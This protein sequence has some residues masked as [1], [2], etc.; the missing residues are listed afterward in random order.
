MTSSS[1]ENYKNI[2]HPDDVDS[3]SL[4][5]VSLWLEWK[6]IPYEHL[7][8][9]EEM[10]ELIRHHLETP[11]SNEEHAKTNDTSHDVSKS[12]VLL[13]EILAKDK[14]MKEEL[15]EVY[16]ELIKFMNTV[17]DD[18]RSVMEQIHGDFDE[19]LATYDRELVN[20]E[21]PIVVA[22]ETSAG[23]SSLL[24]LILGTDVLPHSLLCATSTICRLHNSKSKKFEIITNENEIIPIEVNNENPEKEE[25]L[26]KEK[27]K[28]YVSSTESR[29][30]HKYKQVEIYWPI[31]LLQ[32]RVTIVDTPGVGE[33]DEISKRLFE[34]L[35]N[36]VAFI[37]VINS[38]NSGG[39][40]EDRLLQILNEQ[41]RWQIEGRLTTF[42]YNSTIF[43]CNKWD[44]VEKRHEED[45]V[46]KDTE[47]KLQNALPN[48]PLNQVF[49]MS[50]T[51]AERYKKSRMG[52][53]EKFRSLL[54]GVE[55]LV[56]ASLHAKI[57]R[58]FQFLEMF[59][60]QLQSKIMSRIN[61]A[62]K[63]EEEKNKLY[64]DVV[65]RLNRLN[66]DSDRVKDGL[67][68]T[69][70]AECQQMVN[71]LHEYLQ[72]GDVKERLLSWREDDAPDIEAEDFEVTKFKADGIIV[73]RILKM[74]KDWEEENKLVKVASE[75]LTKMFKEECQI[76]SKDYTDVNVVVEGMV[77][78]DLPLALGIAPSGK[79][80]DALFT[81]SEKVILAVAA[82]LWVPLV[83]AASLLFLPVGVGM[84]IKETIKAG[85]QRRDYR[86]NKVKYMKEWTMKIME[87]A[88]T[89]E[90]VGSFIF[91]V[92]F[93]NFEKKIVELCE[94]FIPQQ[95][96]AD[97]KQV[98]IIANDRRTSHQILSEF[99]PL[100]Y[101]LKMIMGKLRYYELKYM[102][103][104]MI[105][106]SDLH[107]EKEIGRGNFSDVYLATWTNGDRKERVAMKVLRRKLKGADM[108]SQLEEV[109]CLRKFRHTNI[110]KIYGV[111][112][113]NDSTDSVDNRLTMVLEFCD[114]SLE[115][116]AFNDEKLQCKNFK[117]I[118]ERYEAFTFY[119]TMATGVCDGLTE[120]HQKGYLHRDLKLSNVLVKNN[121][122]KLCDLGF[123][124]MEVAVT[125]TFVG[126]MTHMS[127]ELL[128]HEN[129][130]FSS[131]IYSL[132]IL[133]WELWYGHYAYTES[134]YDGLKTF[135]LL[136][137]IKLGQRP[138]LTW[139]FRP[140]NELSDVIKACWNGDHLKR[141]SASEVGERLRKMY[142]QYHNEAE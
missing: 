36:A 64:E 117:S 59:L 115:D 94:E 4:D 108:V 88:F 137:A 33:S 12:Q 71:K 130:T 77:D 31:P 105:E 136:D 142:R 57:G 82:P 29:E 40:Q 39:I 103:K 9:L 128:K 84:F 97:Q 7:E 22:G 70:K 89:E 93:G 86:E 72:S 98:N 75:R 80:N 102:A 114:K 3:L 132:A 121:I 34:Y 1:D 35:P 90:N 73:G 140:T 60:Q 65:R 2:K 19:K 6:G 87:S 24:N 79:P 68:N 67:L 41:N 78:E 21:C 91:G 28:P 124:R 134:D 54:D 95:I 5:E 76:I 100:L 50:V 66:A 20:N 62:K 61:H 126:T 11:D 99:Q 47:A 131:D 15:S 96:A 116:I 27:L 119:V 111:C 58:H 8:N 141:P 37:Y 56:P 44:I 63:S 16:L 109:E 101:Q 123:A 92:Y 138:K 125:G 49:R 74:L 30:E 53:T 135:Q 81:K 13:E 118:P 129:Y 32:D 69:A 46:W 55:K 38:A 51:E 85:K 26:L 127:P 10:Q 112:Y 17:G 14:K 113:T 120:M 139:K 18:L 110:V 106:Q 133:L 52:L 43:V 122:A 83:T 48:F 23:K 104:D 25:E 45:K 42:D 107:I